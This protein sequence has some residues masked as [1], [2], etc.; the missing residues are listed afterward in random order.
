MVNGGGRFVSLNYTKEDATRGRRR[1][2]QQVIAVQR[3]RRRR[4]IRFFSFSLSLPS[5][6]EKRGNE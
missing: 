5:I 4:L 1:K 2:C 3:R 6:C